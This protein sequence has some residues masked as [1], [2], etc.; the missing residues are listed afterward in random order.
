MSIVVRGRVSMV[1][2]VKMTGGDTTPPPNEN[3][4]SDYGSITLAPTSTV[5]GGSV[6]QPATDTLDYGF[7]T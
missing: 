6:S 3:L 4:V 5:D 7:I 1:N 2:G